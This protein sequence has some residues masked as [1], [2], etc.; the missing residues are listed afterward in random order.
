MVFCVVTLCGLVDSNVS[1]ESGASIFRVKSD[2]S[3]DNV[4]L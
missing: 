3:K 1:E 4:K 2:Q